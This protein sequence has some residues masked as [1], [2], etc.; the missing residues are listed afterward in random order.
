M[1]D[2]TDTE[3][4][5]TRSK[6]G[7]WS[8][9]ALVT[10]ATLVN[11]LVWL[12]WDQRRDVQPDGSTTGPYEPWQVVGLAVVLI[13]VV[14][15]AGYRGRPVIAV[16]VGTLVMTLCFSVDA[17][18]EPPEHN[19]GSWAVGA[20]MLTVGTFGGLALVAAIAHAFRRARR[21]GGR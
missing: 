4:A 2:V 1:S 12:G 6:A 7:L 16:V 5:E 8:T 19:D 18:T 21:P 17:V 13:A 9:A 14:A 11:Y 20:I 15:L 3:A 10:V